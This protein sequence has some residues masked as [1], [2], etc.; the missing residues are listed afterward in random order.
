MGTGFGVT[1]VHM[2]FR[3]ELDV[4]AP[5]AKITEQGFADGDAV[6]VI[7]IFHRILYEALTSVVACSTPYGR[8]KA[9]MRNGI[10]RGEP[11]DF[12]RKTCGRGA[13]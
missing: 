7:A 2:E 8:P 5:A 12:V 9:F 3:A 13:K 6:A 10:K 1:R 4:V 11:E